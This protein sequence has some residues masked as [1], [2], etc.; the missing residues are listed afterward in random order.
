MADG[1]GYVFRQ[2]FYGDWWI[3]AIISSRMDGMHSQQLVTDNILAPAG[4]AIDYPTNRLYWADMKA[5]KIET[6]KLDGTNRQL[7]KHF[8]HGQMLFLDTLFIFWFLF[9]LLYLFLYFAIIDLR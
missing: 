6:V 2:L 3:P 7:V 5:N 4:L 8:S 9:I 1:G